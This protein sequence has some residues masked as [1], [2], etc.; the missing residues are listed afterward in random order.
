MRTG[1]DSGAFR[2]W[3]RRETAHVAAER[4]FVR[5]AVGALAMTAVRRL[6]TRV[7]LVERTP[8]ERVAHEGFPGLLAQVPPRHR[9]AAILA[10]HVAFGAVAGAVFRTLPNGVRARRWSGPAYGLAIWAAYEA[11]VA[12]L[13]LRVER[14]RNRPVAERVAIAADHALYGLVLASRRT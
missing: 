10:A 13:V 9:G 6:T 4:L 14:R 3:S 8:P 11:G 1:R 7:G 12:P 2:R 5:G